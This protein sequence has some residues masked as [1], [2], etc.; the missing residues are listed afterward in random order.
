MFEA[1]SSSADA[2]TVAVAELPL[3]SILSSLDRE[4]GRDEP[5]GLGL[6]KTVERV[7]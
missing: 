2:D 5:S 1:A 3:D 7:C 4:R 6:Q